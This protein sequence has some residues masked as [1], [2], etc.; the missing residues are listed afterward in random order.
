MKTRYRAYVVR[1]WWFPDGQERM[2]VRQGVTREPYRCRSLAEA[3][4]WIQARNQPQEASG[5]I[6]PCG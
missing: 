5:T 2:G 4:A 1:R 3:T 6:P